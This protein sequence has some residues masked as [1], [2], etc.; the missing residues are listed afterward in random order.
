MPLFIKPLILSLIGLNAVSLSGLAQV[1]KITGSVKLSTKL[2]T[3][4]CNLE[5]SN[6]PKLKKY[7][8]WLNAGLNVRYFRDSSDEFNY[9]YNKYFLEDKS[10]WKIRDR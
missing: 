8:I 1:P 2:G 3:I 7:S 6:I 9:D 4:E 5:I 10:M